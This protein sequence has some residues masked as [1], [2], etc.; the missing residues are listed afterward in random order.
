MSGRSDHFLWPSQ[1]EDIARVRVANHAVVRRR[2]V[3]AGHTQTELN[4]AES[5]DAEGRFPL[6]AR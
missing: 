3:R 4:A 5:S 6:A 2:A 1:A